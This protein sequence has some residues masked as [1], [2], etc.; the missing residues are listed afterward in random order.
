MLPS[1]TTGIL[2]FL[3]VAAPGIL[4][5]LL[6]KRHRP[7]WTESVLHE[8]GR[9][10]LAS[11][12][13]TALSLLVLAG[14]RT[15][16]AAAMPD[17]E[18]WL[19]DGSKYVPDNY[20]LIARTAILLLFLSLGLAWA[21]DWLL[22]RRPGGDLRRISAWFALF[23]AGAPQG[24]LPYARVR[25]KSGDVY[26]GYVVYYSEELPLSDR[27]LV[28]GAPL[29]HRPPDGDSRELDGRWQRI[30]VSGSDVEALWVSYI[31]S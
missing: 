5:D 4:F 19:R 9:I 16:W 3:L 6:R 10:I 31:K 14:L 21:A 30:M 12:A 27:E 23:R 26:A 2:L 15:A 13:L 11:V 25:L 22:R 7:G 8:T 29:V 18:A 24:A 20:R 17:I 28:L 1:T